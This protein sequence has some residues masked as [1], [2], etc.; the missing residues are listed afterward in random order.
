MPSFFDNVDGL[1]VVEAH[2]QRV[3]GLED[4]QA[5][6]IMAQYSAVRRELRDR[7]DRSR[8]TSFTAQHLRGVLAQIEGA[9]SALNIRLSG[10]LEESAIDMAGLGIDDLLDE[11]STFDGEFTD[12][13][14][15]INLNV[16]LIA[17]DTSQF[18]VTKYQTNL[19]AYGTNLMTQISNGLFS[20]SI[21]EKSYGQ[22]VQKIGMFFQAEEWKLSRIVRTELHNIYNIGKMNGMGE[23]V[24]QGVV[25]DLY[26]TLM[27]PMDARTGDDS[28][29]AASQHL[30][31]K[32]DAPFKYKWKGKMRTF[33]APPDR[34]NDRAILVPY[35]KAWGSIEADAFIPM[36][37]QE[38]RK[39][40]WL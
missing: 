18:L 16:A 20:A 39:P 40:A 4:T 8:A 36:N 3:L 7:L 23:L 19:D 33:M 21:G 28:E 27:H 14:T 25:P 38:P 17:R 9:I 10:G 12:A 26:K 6:K 24:D 34:P 13:I 30:V 22:V 29:Y 15:P 35:R 1:G 37:A 31:A 11:I 2:I 5:K 32:V